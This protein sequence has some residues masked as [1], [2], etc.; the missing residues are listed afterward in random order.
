MAEWRNILALVIMMLAAILLSACGPDA[1]YRYKM[2]VEVETPDGIKAGHAV[3]EVH[4]YEGGGF[5]FGEGRPQMRLTGEAVAIDLPRGRTLFALLTGRDGYED[6]SHN[7]ISAIFRVMDRDI[8]PKGG[9]HELWPK[10]PVIREPITDPVPAL[11]TFRDMRDPKS[12]EL[13]DPDDLGKSFGPGYRLKSITIE[14]TDEPVTSAIGKRLSEEFF[15]DW[16]Y[17]GSSIAH[18]GQLDHPYF[19][20]LATRIGRWSFQRTDPPAR[21]DADDLREDMKRRTLLSAVPCEELIPGYSGGPLRRIYDPPVFQHKPVVP[22]GQQQRT[23]VARWT[24]GPTPLTSNWTGELQLLDG[25]IAV[26]SRQMLLLFPYGEGEW[27]N[28]RQT[29]SYDGKSYAIGDRISLKGDAIRLFVDGGKAEYQSDSAD[30][31]K[32][33]FRSCNG[34][35]IFRVDSKANQ[36]RL[37]SGAL[38]P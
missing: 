29:L 17:F 22:S 25:C 4:Y 38:A 37:R 21:F 32:H 14:V 7:G 11:V 8:G 18:C 3:R 34:Y 24:P 12:I 20:Q 27:N 5:M 1:K 30:L 9:P 13:V 19:R 16:E 35:E 15:G 6:Y 26:G 31:G 10:V 2:V 36:T 33:D 28:A 23:E